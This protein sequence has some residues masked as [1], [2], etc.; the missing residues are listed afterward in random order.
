MLARM[1]YPKFPVALGVLYAVT[2]PTYESALGLQAEAARQ[3]FGTGD[4]RQ[5]LHSGNTWTV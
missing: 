5:L 4:L 1:P 2:R 3:K